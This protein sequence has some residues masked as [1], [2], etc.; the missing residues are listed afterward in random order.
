MRILI[1]ATDELVDGRSRVHQT[2][3]QGS[4][5]QRSGAHAIGG[6][7]LDALGRE[8]FGKSLSGIPRGKGEQCL[9]GSVAALSAGND[10]VVVELSRLATKSDFSTTYEHAFAIEN[11][12][13]VWPRDLPRLAML[14][15]WVDA[16]RGIVKFHQT[17]MVCWLRR[18]CGAL[19]S[20]LMGQT[21]VLADD[22]LFG[23]SGSR[24][25]EEGHTLSRLDFSW[26]AFSICLKR[27][28]KES[29][30]GSSSLS[31]GE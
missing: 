30:M 7:Q 2:S 23:V 19:V 20:Q 18:G 9:S 25:L 21:G 27:C 12:G 15:S 8:D 22:L 6:E 1:H 24:G 11:H 17:V 26:S 14:A 3:I 10:V 31:G 29:S 4:V 16:Y 28:K 5:G 13:D